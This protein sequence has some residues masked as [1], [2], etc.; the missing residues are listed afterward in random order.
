MVCLCTDVEMK[1]ALVSQNPPLGVQASAQDIPVAAGEAPVRLFAWL[2]A[3]WVALIA[4]V[5]FTEDESGLRIISARRATAQ[6]RK[7]YEDQ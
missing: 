7:R 5:V 3:A 4:Y 2:G 1:S 6:E